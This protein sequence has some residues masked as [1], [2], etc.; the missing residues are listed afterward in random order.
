MIEQ[1]MCPRTN[2]HM[3]FLV[4]QTRSAILGI[5]QVYANKACPSATHGTNKWVG[6]IKGKDAIKWDTVCIAVRN[7]T[8]RSIDGNMAGHV[9]NKVGR[10]VGFG[11]HHQD[12]E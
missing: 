5:L 10:I 7:Y 11:Q 3:V 4:F 2:F 9:Q 8:S 12:S 1:F 6:C